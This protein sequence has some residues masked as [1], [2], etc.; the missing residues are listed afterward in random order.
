MQ[1]GDAPLCSTLKCGAG[2]SPA[3]PAAGRAAESVPG[4]LLANGL[5]PRQAGSAPGRLL[6]LVASAA[7]AR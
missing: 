3:Q 2:F 7:V 6:A 1:A 5:T 4:L